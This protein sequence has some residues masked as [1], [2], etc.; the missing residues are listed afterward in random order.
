MCAA[1]YKAYYQLEKKLA[2]APVNAR[3]L[4]NSKRVS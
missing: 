4:I 1:P 3:E 2:V